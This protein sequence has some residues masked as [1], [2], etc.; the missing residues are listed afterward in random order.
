MAEEKPTEEQYGE[1]EID[2]DGYYLYCSVCGKESR[3]GI[4]TD[5]C[6]EC[7]IKMKKER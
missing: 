2:C 5:V 6:G 1:W 7:G 4:K 3:T